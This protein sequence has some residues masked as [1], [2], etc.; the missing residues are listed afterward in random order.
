MKAFDIHKYLRKSILNLK[1]YRSAREE[2]TGELRHMILLDANENPYDT[3]INRYPDPMQWELKNRLAKFRNVEP[4]SIYLAHGS[5]EI[6]GQLIMA[7]CEPGE[8]QIMILPPTFGMYAVAAKLHGVG[9]LEVPLTT[10][11]Q[12]NISAILE[13][14]NANSKILFIPCPNNPTGNHFSEK[15]LKKIIAQFDGIVVVDEA[16]V[17]FSSRKSVLHLLKSHPNLIVCQ[18]FSKA[19]GMAGARFGMAFA[20]PDVI[21]GLHRLKMPYNMNILTTRAVMKRLDN[22]H[23]VRKQVD[24]LLKEKVRLRQKLTQFDCVKTV[25]PS[26][27]NFILIR[28]DHS[29][30]RY[31]Q[32]LHKKIIVRHTAHYLHCE[33]TLRITVGRPFENNELLK[34]FER[35][36]RL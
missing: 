19:Q 25:Y 24:I 28:V 5:D 34:A 35:I 32:L 7:F 27:A 15:D 9:V 2:Y 4:E 33:N 1:P 31:E 11:F 14:K 22:Q 17:E 29:Q 26:D 36:D 10:Q 3:A 12:L 6:M 13:Q 18:T 16:Y 30:R 21:Q 20:H 23:L 8:D